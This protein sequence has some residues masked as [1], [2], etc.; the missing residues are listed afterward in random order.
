MISEIDQDGN[1][2]ISFNEFVWL[3]TRWAF[4]SSSRLGFI[5]FKKV[6][7]E[8]YDQDIESEIREAFI[9][10]DKEGHGF[11]S[12]SGRGCSRGWFLSSCLSYSLFRS[13]SCPGDC[14]GEADPW[15]DCSKFVQCII[16]IIK[17]N[18]IINNWLIINWTWFSSNQ[19][20]LNA[21][22]FNFSSSTFRFSV[23]IFNLIFLGI[24]LRS[25]LRWRRKH[26]LWRIHYDVV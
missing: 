26:K 18:Y 11:I 3:M 10:F 21:L 16:I 23:S 6:C 1:G 7:R 4:I 5:S 9:I 24:Y 20:I 13:H 14:G 25:W 15:W 22:F 12:V 17:Y 2:Q 8:I 19:N